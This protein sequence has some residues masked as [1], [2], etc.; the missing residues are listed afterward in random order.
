ML[1]MSISDD[2]HLPSAPLLVCLHFNHKIVQVFLLYSP[3]RFTRGIPTKHSQKLSTLVIGTSRHKDSNCRTFN[4]KVTGPLRK[5]FTKNFSRVQV[6]K[7][8]L[9]WSILSS[10]RSLCHLSW[11]TPKILVSAQYNFNISKLRRS[12]GRM[13]IAAL[14]YPNPKPQETWVVADCLLILRKSFLW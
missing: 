13:L 1:Q 9:I 2:N 5:I 7:S 6:T 4:W 3:P 10:I 12:C 14:L 8:L 11:G